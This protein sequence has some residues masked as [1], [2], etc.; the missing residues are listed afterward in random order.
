MSE[1]LSIWDSVL[2]FWLSLADW[3]NQQ[4]AIRI[5]IFM[6]L[7]SLLVSYRRSSGLPAF[8]VSGTCVSLSNAW[9]AIRVAVNGQAGE[10]ICAIPMVLLIMGSWF[11][12][13]DTILPLNRSRAL[14][15]H[16]M[17]VS[18][19]VVTGSFTIAVM[20]ISDPRGWDRLVRGT[21]V[22]CQRRDLA[23]A[24]CIGPESCDCFHW[25]LRCTSVMQLWTI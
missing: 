21:E 22:R 15:C 7:A 13:V 11:T 19:L 23:N 1:L 10:W 17:V 25:I 2:S 16:M 8:I 24:A 5:G 9:W 6:L 20:G 18:A 4:N 12:T 14:R 3:L